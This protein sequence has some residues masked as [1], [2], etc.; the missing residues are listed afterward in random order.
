MTNSL[1]HALGPAPNFDPYPTM[2]EYKYW[3]M[4]T[5]CDI[6]CSVQFYEWL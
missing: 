1:S 3:E 2:F 4:L 5:D 6:Y